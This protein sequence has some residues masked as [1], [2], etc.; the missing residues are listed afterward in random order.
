MSIMVLDET[1]ED[2]CITAK[3]R[4]WRLPIWMAAAGATL[5][6]LEKAADFARRLAFLVFFFI[7][8]DPCLVYPL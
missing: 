5:F 7:F 3:L 4:G 2:G 8:S 1:A 6:A